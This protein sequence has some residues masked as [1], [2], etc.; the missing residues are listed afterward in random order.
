MDGYSTRELLMN[1]GAFRAQVRQLNDEVK[2]GKAWRGIFQ[3]HGVTGDE[4]KAV[5]TDLIIESE[6]FAVSPPGT[7]T[8]MLHR[9]EGKREVIAR[10]LFLLD[11]PS[12]FITELRRD[13]LD[14]L[15]KLEER[16]NNGG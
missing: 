9:R 11:L 6:Y 12:S 7:S 10:I 4:A 13:A 8:E 14:E 15:Q 16:A 2:L 1:D 5:L 3:G